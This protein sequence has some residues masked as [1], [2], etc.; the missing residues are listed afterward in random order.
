MA[1]NTL[2]VSMTVAGSEQKVPVEE[3]ISYSGLGEN[4]TLVVKTRHRT[5]VRFSK[6]VFFGDIPNAG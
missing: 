6:N 2:Y 3:V 5:T 4:T 1:P